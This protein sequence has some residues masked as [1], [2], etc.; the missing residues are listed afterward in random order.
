M[1]DLR[2]GLF[3]AS[4]IDDETGLLA[5]IIDFETDTVLARIP[6]DDETSYLDPDRPTDRPWC[7]TEVRMVPSRQ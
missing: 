4:W 3:F 2:D 7:W 5:Q 6:I 1:V